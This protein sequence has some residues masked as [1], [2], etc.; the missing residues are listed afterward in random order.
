MSPSF[1]LF[2]IG[3]GIAG[4]KAASEAAARGLSVGL[5][6]E[7]MFGG[8][9]LNVNHLWPGLDGAPESG[10]ELAAELMGR[11]GELGVTMVSDAVSAVT[12]EPDGS[13]A[14][15]TADGLHRARCVIVA[16][17]A[18]LR[19]LGV[20]GEAEF[21]DRGVSHCADCDAPLYTG[22]TV[23]VVGGGDSALQEALVLAEFCSAV[24]VVHRGGAF[25]ARAAFVEA[26]GKAPRIETRFHTVVQSLQGD[27]A[28]SAVE[29]GDVR[30]GETY[31]Q[32]CKSVFVYVGLEPNVSFLPPG[33]EMDAGGIRVS[34]TLESSL[35]GLYAI[36][37]VR[38]G[39]GGQLTHA[40][41]DAGIAVLAC[42][43][44]IGKG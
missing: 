32:A 4:L 22:Q 35:D 7:R 1:D 44:R 42:C 8:L 20:P 41:Q 12:S 14:V 9:A 6:E 10:S 26:V 19:R 13:L 16:S 39:F 36:G 23:V 34:E 18:R 24:I 2:V 31:L 30:S 5:A 11:V 25:T 43:G 37:A 27:D 40:V 33:V 28:V 29:L 38:S 21:E 17:G 15:A 3:A